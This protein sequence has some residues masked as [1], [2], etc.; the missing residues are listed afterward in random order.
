MHSP[1]KLASK[2][3]VP[4]VTADAVLTMIAV[5]ARIVEMENCILNLEEIALLTCVRI[6]CECLMKW[7]R[8][9]V[10]GKDLWV[11]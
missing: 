10:V 6:E 4:Q 7:M 3:A 8:M 5:A 2:Q 1:A 9:K 11:L